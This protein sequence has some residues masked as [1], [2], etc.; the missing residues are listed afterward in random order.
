MSQSQCGWPS[1]QTSLP[2]AGLVGHYPTNNLIGRRPLQ[3]RLAALGLSPHAVLAP[4]SQGYPPPLD[5][6]LRV[7]HPSAT[8]DP[9]TARATCMC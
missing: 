9:K 3:G 7:T 2:I 5:T 8:D 4:V 6:F 1:S